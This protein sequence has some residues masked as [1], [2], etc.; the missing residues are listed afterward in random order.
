[1][2]LTRA[3]IAGGYGVAGM[4]SDEDLDVRKVIVQLVPKGIKLK[5]NNTQCLEKLQDGFWIFRRLT[6]TL[7]M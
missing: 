3:S 2:Q 5:S 6:T 7:Q 1:V 4:F